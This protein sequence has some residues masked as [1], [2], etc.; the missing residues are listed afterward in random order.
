MLG[1]SALKT[2]ITMRNM[3]TVLS[4]RVAA[5]VP[6]ANALYCSKNVADECSWFSDVD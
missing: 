2:L 4:Q 1:L 5:I 6:A 3:K